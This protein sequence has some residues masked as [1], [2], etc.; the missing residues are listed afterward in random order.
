MGGLSGLELI[1]VKY[2]YLQLVTKNV[3]TH[4]FKE[5]GLNKGGGL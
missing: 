2:L 4:K 1:P 3:D 5:A